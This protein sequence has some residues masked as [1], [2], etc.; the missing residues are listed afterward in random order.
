MA[1][2]ARCECSKSNKRQGRV[3]WRPCESRPYV[4][5]RTGGAGQSRCWSDR[6]G[7]GQRHGPGAEPAPDP[8]LLGPGARIWPVSV[9]RSGTEMLRIGRP[10]SSRG[11]CAGGGRASPAMW[12]LH[13]ALR[14]VPIGAGWNPCGT[15]SST[16]FGAAPGPRG[17]PP[18]PAPADPDRYPAGPPRQAHPRKARPNRSTRAEEP[19]AFEAA[20]GPWACRHRY[21]TAGGRRIPA[22]SGGTGVS[23]RKNGSEGSWA[24]AGASVRRKRSRSRP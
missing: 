18:P 7:P 24:L 5:G 19:T 17:V 8:A 2:C 6:P 11:T 4:R 10:V 23:G 22:R 1:K 12:P 3:W 16:A 14:P 20:P 21:S 13:R 9:R 15:A